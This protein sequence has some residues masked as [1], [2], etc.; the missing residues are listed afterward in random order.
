M[1]A[2]DMAVAVPA[3]FAVACHPEASFV[4][5][6]W[7]SLAGPNMSKL[8]SL[9]TFKAM[10]D[11]RDVVKSWV[12]QQLNPILPQDRLALAIAATPEGTDPSFDGDEGAVEWAKSLDLDDYLDS[13][14]LRLLPYYPDDDGEG[15]DGDMV[16]E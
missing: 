6:A 9:L 8:K 13:R 12:A 3:V 16:I 5:Q 7:T 2:A 15:D 11:G 14:V 4:E 10:Y 1:A